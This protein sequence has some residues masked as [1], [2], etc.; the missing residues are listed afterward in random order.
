[1]SVLLR[2]KGPLPRHAHGH[3][4]LLSSSGWFLT[5]AVCLEM[6][7][8]VGML[9]LLVMHNEKV[10]FLMAAEETK[11]ATSQAAFK[12]KIFFTGGQQGHCILRL[13]PSRVD[14]P[15]MEATLPLISNLDGNEL[16]NHRSI[17]AFGLYPGHE[18]G[19]R[20]GVHLSGCAQGSINARPGQGSINRPSSVSAREEP[21][22]IMRC[23][24]HITV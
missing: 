22:S 18:E 23:G 17:L 3:G 8:D 13:E 1:M 6:G 19:Q 5:D 10:S 21:S 4:L 2:H 16:W 15:F 20:N 24:S 11:P 7:I 12:G 9:C 14:L